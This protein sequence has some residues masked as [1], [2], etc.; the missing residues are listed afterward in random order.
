MAPKLSR[1]ERKELEITIIS[2]FKG[3]R[4]IT[5]EEIARIFP[6]CTTRTV[7]NARSNIMRYGTIDRPSKPFGRPAEVTENMWMAIWHELRRR[8]SLS[9]QAQADFLYKLYGI[10]V[11][12][13]TISRGVKWT[14]KMMITIAK[15]RNRDLRDDYIHR[16]SF[17]KPSQMVF[18][19]EAGDD[20]ELAIPKKGYA[21]KGV[22]PVQVKPFHRGKRVSFLP[23]YTID[24]VIYS[25]V[26]EGNTDLEVFESFLVNLL[27]HCGRYPEPRSVVIMDNA[28]FHNISQTIKDLFAEAGVLIVNSLHTLQT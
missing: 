22:T 12:S 24:G 23:A 15:E 9:Q 5:D 20:R 10:R 28:S 7:R 25:Q 16:R 17:F 11:S 21:P 27:P 14:K 3:N 1:I 19:D 26:Y 13:S 18:V 6:R 8:P 2:K 4:K